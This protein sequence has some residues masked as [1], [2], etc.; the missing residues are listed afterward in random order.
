MIML[1]LKQMLAGNKDFIGTFAALCGLVAGPLLTL[2]KSSLGVLNDRSWERK[3]SKSAEK[4]AQCL[5]DL[6]DADT[7]NP[8]VPSETIE[9]YR[10]MLRERLQS[11]LDQLRLVRE[12]QQR[13]AQAMWEKPT[14]IHRWLLL[15]RPFGLAG[16]L[17]QSSFY[18]LLIVSLIMLAVVICLPFTAKF[19][20]G[21]S[22]VDWIILPFIFLIWGLWPLLP[23]SVALR[24][25]EFMIL[26]QG[27]PDANADLSPWSRR[28]LL[29]KSPSTKASV[30]R[31]FAYFCVVE[32]LASPA[33]ARSEAG[34]APVS[35]P[36]YFATA[37][38]FAALA[39]LLWYDV[40]LRRGMSRLTTSVTPPP[41]FESAVPRQPH[42]GGTCSTPSV[43]SPS[44]SISTP[45]PSP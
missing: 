34:A 30:E 37:G 26:S 43:T 44:S 18:A 4:I 13:R 1:W 40:L 11:A 45:F 39:A 22:P 19:R 41:Y 9:P 31:G 5:K 38:L 15:F 32:C 10:V 3:S 42:P 25:K 29:F 6:H 24:R 12:R 7:P 21:T 36:I 16:W 17:I 14:G 33:V 20:Y 27:R 28:L 2:L 8:Q 23:R 35:Y